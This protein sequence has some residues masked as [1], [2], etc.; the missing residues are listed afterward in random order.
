[1][2]STL[3]MRRFIHVS[4]S[5]NRDW[6][7]VISQILTNVQEIFLVMWM[8][9]VPTQLDHMYVH[10]TLDTLETDKLAQ[11]ILITFLQCPEKSFWPKRGNLHCCSFYT[12]NPSYSKWEVIWNVFLAQIKRPEVVNHLSWNSSPI[13]NCGLFCFFPYPLRL[14]LQYFG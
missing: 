2:H 3:K 11:V 5:K 10:A 12:Y 7:P 4:Y 9:T 1:M 8:L 13:K 6:K 14:D